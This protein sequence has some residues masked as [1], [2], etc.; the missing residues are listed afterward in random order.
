VR[1]RVAEADDEARRLRVASF[2]EVD[3]IALDDLDVVGKARLR[4]A[5]SELRAELGARLDGDDAEAEPRQ[6]DRVGARARA[7][8]QR[9]RADRPHPAGV[10]DAAKPA[11][12]GLDASRE[13]TEHPRVN[14]GQELF[15]VGANRCHDCLLL[16]S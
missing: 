7:E 1:E 10:D 8:I 15:V 3:E 4:G 9:E 12:L 14:V 6:C 5:P 11:E 16:P 2:E 13:V